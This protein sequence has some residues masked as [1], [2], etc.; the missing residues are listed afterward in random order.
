MPTASSI[1]PILSGLAV[2][3]IYGFVFWRVLK[4]KRGNRVI[5]CGISAL[6]VLFSWGPI[7]KIPNVP[8][9]VPTAVGLLMFLLCLLTMFFLFLQGVHALRNRK[10][11]AVA[12]HLSGDEQD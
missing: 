7:S 1:R 3:A 6:V 2:A 4:S 8:D 12:S 10:P 5:E 9:W 11:K